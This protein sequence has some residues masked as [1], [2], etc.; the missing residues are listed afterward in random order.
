MSVELCN[1]LPTVTSNELGGA[2][3]RRIFNDSHWEVLRWQYDELAQQKD[4][5][6]AL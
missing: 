4:E 1:V 6:V 3:E 2:V 5:T